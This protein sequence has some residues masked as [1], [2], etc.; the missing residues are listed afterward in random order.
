MDGPGGSPVHNSRFLGGRQVDIKPVLVFFDA[1]LFFP[2]CFDTSW[3]G[4]SGR[5]PVTRGGR[6]GVMR[7]CEG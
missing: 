1:V 3:I 2:H 6:E 5:N 7:V 4:L